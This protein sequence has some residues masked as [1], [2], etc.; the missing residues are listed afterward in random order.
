MI[1]EMWPIGRVPPAYEEEQYDRPVVAGGDG[2]VL[3]DARSVPV[4]PSATGCQ[5]GV[6]P[7]L[8]SPVGR[9]SLSSL[10][11]LAGQSSP[12]GC[13]LTSCVSQCMSRPVVAGG[14][15]QPVVAGGVVEVCVVQSAPRPPP[16]MTSR[17]SRT[18]A[19]CAALEAVRTH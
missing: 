11:V 10:V 17:G 4:L 9:P 2:V 16:M 8:S 7:N 13:C 18:Y 3:V 19:R 6:C 14:L 12:V 15:S 5:P 1:I